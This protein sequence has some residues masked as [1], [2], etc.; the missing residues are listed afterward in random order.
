MCGEV[1]LVGVLRY[2]VE[3]EIVILVGSFFLYE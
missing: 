3:C 2:V 1:L